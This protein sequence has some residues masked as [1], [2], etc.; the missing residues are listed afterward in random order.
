MDQRIIQFVAALRASGVRISLAESEDAFHAI[1]NLGIQDREV[2]RISLRSSMIKN[3]RDFARFDELFPLFFQSGDVPP[4]LHPDQELTPEEAQMLAQAMRQYSGRLKKMLEKLMKGEPLTPQE[5]QQLDQFVNMD[6]VTDMR[7]QN[8]IARQ[9]EQALRFKDVREAMRELSELLS[10][11]GM[12][13]KRLD[14][15]MKAMQSN[16]DAIHQQIRQHVGQRIAEN[17]SRQDPKG[18]MDGLYNRPFRTLSDEDIQQL[19]HEVQRLAAILRTRLALRMKRARTGQLDAKATIRANLKNDSVPIEL[20]H[21]NHALKPKIVVLCDISTSMRT[22]SEL[23]L[24]MLYSIQDQISKTY[25]YAFIDDM[26]FISPYFVGRQPS[27]AVG[28]VLQEMPSGY[29]NTDFGYS[30]NTFTHDFLNTVDR[31]STVIVVGDARNNYNDP[32]LKNFQDV[33]R[34]SRMAIWLN[35][36]ATPLWGTGDSDML[37]YAPYCQKTFQVSN[38]SQLSKAIDNLLLS[39]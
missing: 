9:M 20:K 11:M 21:R 29:Y 31:Y 13:R 39:L 37:K 32:N 22:C 28:A 23:M 35:P 12:N 2:F 24:S 8:W 3:S 16:Q 5:M 6:G 18:R 7:Y 26:K 25:A 27:E 15:L 4:L 38:L 34:R 33:V 17:L 1:E 19:H 36:E 30:L 14:R 10:Q